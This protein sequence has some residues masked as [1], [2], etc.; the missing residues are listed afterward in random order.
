MISS[1][2][3]PSA[4]FLNL[5]VR[6]IYDH[7]FQGVDQPVRVRDPDQRVWFVPGAISSGDRAAVDIPVRAIAEM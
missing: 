7:L 2:L 5:I 3:R 4:M 6:R 1:S